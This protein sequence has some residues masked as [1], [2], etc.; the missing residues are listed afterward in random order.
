MV[1]L[2]TGT[3][4]F[5]FAEI[6]GSARL[7]QQ[8]GE[9]YADVLARSRRLVRAA[10]EE[11]CGHNIDSKG[12]AFCFAFPRARDA[13]AA[14]IGAQR[15]VLRHPWAHGISVRV[16]MGLYTGEALAVDTG[17]AGI[18][19]HTA[20]R[21]GAAS[22]GGQ[23]LVSQTTRDLT[24]DALPDGISLRDLGEHRLKALAHPHHLFQ[25][26]AADLPSDFPALWSLDVLPNNLPR[27]LTSF[28]G[29]ERE[30]GEVKRLLSTT[31]LL[32][33]TGTGGSGKTRL[34]MQ[35][36]ADLLEDYADGAW[37]TELAPLSDPD[38]V[39]QAVASNLGVR[40]QP[41]RSL[42]QTIIDHVRPK[43]QLL[44]MDNCEHVLPACAQ[45][46]DALLRGCPHIR[47]LATSRE[48]LGIGGELT[49]RVPSLSLPELHRS[50]SPDTMKQYEAV[51]LFAERAAFSQPG[52]QITPDNAVAVS[53]ICQRLDGI[54]L[55]I[56]LAAARVRVLAVGQIAARLDDRF[57][58]LTAGSRTA[59]PRHQTLQAAIDWSYELLSE[60]ERALFRALSVFPGGWTLEGAEAVCGDNL[61]E[62]TRV[63][64]LLAQLVD[65]S[66]VTVETQDR[67]ARY[68][69][70]ETIRAYARR[71]AASAEQ[72]A[73]ERR[74]AAFFLAVAERA[75][76]HLGMGAGQGTWLNQ[77]AAELDN[78]RAALRYAAAWSETE[79][80]LRL[81]AALRWFWYVRGHWS[82]GREWLEGALAGGGSTSPRARAKALFAAGF[83]ARAAG[84][85]QRAYAMLEESL[86]LHRGL[87]DK[88][89]TASCLAHLGLAALDQG[90]YDRATS[91]HKEGLALFRELRNI[92]DTA[93]CLVYLA[94]SAM[95]SQTA[96]RY[97]RA[98]ASGQEALALFRTAAYPGGTGLALVNLALIAYHQGDYGRARTLAGE[99]LAL[100]RELGYEALGAQAL[101][102]LGLV[103]CHQADHKKAASLLAES[104]ALAW[105]LGDRLRTAQCVEGLAE[106]ASAQRQWERAARLY[107]AAESL[108]VVLGVSITPWEAPARDRRVAAVRAKLNAK[109]AATAWAAGAST[110]LDR[111]VRDL[112]EAVGPR[113]SACPDDEPAGTHRLTARE[114]EI[115]ALIAQGLANRDIAAKLVITERTAANH[116]QHILNKL[117]FDSRAQIAVWAVERGLR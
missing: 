18:D 86:S 24:A 21:I 27:Q 79:T 83:L 22:H 54:P 40:E 49:Y 69:L 90:L 72:E 23:I 2:P 1:S 10:V 13:L 115:A 4:T 28:V 43:S 104:L 84:D 88:S 105:K 71:L 58:L 60:K 42:T 89:G 107:G 103:A 111:L 7:L 55:A 6:E 26:V 3:V 41:G 99:A 31:C 76:P 102:T 101:R 59:L 29:R 64:P 114:Q 5:L 51:R 93:R 106:L 75:E 14:A 57:E 45:L 87:E 117:G 100:S 11:R 109:T 113:S 98:E 112:T 77:I 67:E 63:L 9:R 68:Q 65:K 12:D 95:A 44:L 36:A 32:T 73:L 82:E 110:P 62:K 35:V 78:M 81:T 25:V 20:A 96:Q 39:P 47:I 80:A 38:L 52:F 17:Y 70:L 108:R 50:G 53:Q 8:L 85:Y 97:A 94:R 48:G 61:I 33:L 74:H 91:L 56:E 66:L 46:A 16:R 37:V 15:S 19:V 30:M 116:V 92:V 34:A